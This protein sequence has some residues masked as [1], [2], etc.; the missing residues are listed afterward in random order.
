MKEPADM[1]SLSDEV[2]SDVEALLDMQDEEDDDDA[3]FLEE[4]EKD[5]A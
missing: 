2:D 3:E 4:F 1:F 5:D